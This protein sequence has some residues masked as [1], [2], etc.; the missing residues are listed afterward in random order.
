MA[1]TY[2]DLK[3]EIAGF[4]N[5][6]D[7]TSMVDTF[8]DQCEAEMQVRV[9]ELEFEETS[10]VTVTAGL[11][12]LPTGFLS[13]RS[14]VWNGDT[15]RPLTYVTPAKLDVANAA[16]PSFANYYTIIGGDMRFAD[17]GDGTAIL[18][19]NAKFTPLSD[20]NTSNSILAEFPSAY[21]YGSLVHAATYCK[22]FEA[23]VGYK[24]LFEEQMRLVVQNNADRKYAGAALQ[25]RPG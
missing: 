7:L 21:L 12:T 17:D 13:A 9:K 5:R 14:V 10:T 3:T 8:I 16:S 22:D 4:I 11:A 23:A 2:A 18:T 6:N 24:T 25:V 1:T 19:H 20:S 15:A